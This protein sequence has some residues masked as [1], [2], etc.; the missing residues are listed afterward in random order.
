MA[1]ATPHI[2]RLRIVKVGSCLVL[3]GHNLNDVATVAHPIGE[4]PVTVEEVVD[5]RLVKCFLLKSLI[6]DAV[7]IL[8]QVSRH[9][10]IVTVVG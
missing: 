8:R 2:A 1:P 6:T 7:E 4:L 9:G 3:I 5:L 10:R